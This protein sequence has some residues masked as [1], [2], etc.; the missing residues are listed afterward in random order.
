MEAARQNHGC[1]MSGLTAQ[2]NRIIM[3]CHR[4]VV[5]S[6]NWR[7]SLPCHRTSMQDAC[8]CSRR[9]E[10]KTLADWLEYYNN[11][12]VGSFLEALEKM[13]GFY[14]GLDVNIFKDSV[15]LPGVSL[16]YLLHGTIQGL[17]APELYAPGKEAYEILK[18][19]VMGGPSLV[20]T[21]KYE[22]AEGGDGDKIA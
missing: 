10:V 12:A 17:N 20:F 18:G 2:I 9:G 11:L 4:I 22:G 6:Q 3:D 7:M 15:S 8:E 14:S 19:A 16:Q 21:R 13:R 5:G 1:R